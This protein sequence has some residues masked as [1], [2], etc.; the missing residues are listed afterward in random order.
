MVTFN[1]CFMHDPQIHNIYLANLESDH[2]FDDFEER[3]GPLG[4]VKSKS[5]IR[6][7]VNV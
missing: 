3:L 4:C 7:N 1:S 2:F 6:P 5:C